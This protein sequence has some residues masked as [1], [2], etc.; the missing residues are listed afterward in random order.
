MNDKQLADRIVELGIG[1]SYDNEHNRWYR[2]P[3]KP[4]VGTGW[5]AEAFVHDWRVCGQLMERVTEVGRI[6][7]IGCCTTD[8][9]QCTAL[10]GYGHQ[11]KTHHAVNESLP[12]A[13]NEACVEALD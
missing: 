3:A 8:T 11:A 4:A 5:P 7:F 12:R 6:G 9:F 13:I 2:Y 10:H 1:N